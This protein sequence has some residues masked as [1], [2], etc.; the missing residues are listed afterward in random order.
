MGVL[1]MTLRELLAIAQKIEAQGVSMDT[2][3]K[4]HTRYGQLRDLE[5]ELDVGFYN[6][7]DHPANEGNGAMCLIAYG[8][9]V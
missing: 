4:A 5:L 9:E 6:E 3:I 8:V 1:S 7:K 2:P